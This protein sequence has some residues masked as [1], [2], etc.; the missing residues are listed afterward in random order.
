MAYRSF[1]IT[2]PG[3]TL[4]RAYAFSIDLINY[5]GTMPGV[6]VEWRD[7]DSV[8]LRLESADSAIGVAKMIAGLV[9]R[10][11]ETRI[12]I[13]L[14][15][16]E[17]TIELSGQNPGDAAKVIHQFLAEAIELARESGESHFKKQSKPPPA[18]ASPAA[19]P[20]GELEDLADWAE[21]QGPASAPE[22]PEERKATEVPHKGAYAIT[23]IFYATDRKS[24]EQPLSTTAYGKER[25]PGGNL[26]LG[27]FNVTIPH[28][29]STE[30][31]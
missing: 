3:S 14:C 29:H 21:L 17:R 25:R 5:A 23:Q 18:A 13:K 7:V 6:Q 12:Q 31:L 28:D 9:E 11:G 19:A 24:T 2:F 8:M 20:A 4:D 22:A 1:L 15:G 30:S 26:Y 27:T 16:G 10:V